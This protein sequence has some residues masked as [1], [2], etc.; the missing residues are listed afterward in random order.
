M[1]KIQEYM[2]WICGRDTGV[3]SK[4]IWAVMVGA[5]SSLTHCGG[6][7]DVPHDNQDFGRCYRLLMLFPE[8]EKRLVEVG[9]YLPK[10][11]PFVLAWPELKAL[12]EKEE[13]SSRLF[14][15][16]KECEDE[17]FYLDG[18]RRTGPYSLSRCAKPWWGTVWMWN[19]SN[20]FGNPGLS[21]EDA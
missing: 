10:W 6:E 12:Y 11:R 20:H 3:S 17:G 8:W 7:Y 21:L 15:R 9:R 13:I 5:I 2:R 18:W 4:T 14:E 1:A 16:L 19:H